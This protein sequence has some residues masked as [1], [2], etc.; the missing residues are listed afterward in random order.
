MFQSRVVATANRL[1]LPILCGV[2]LNSL[3]AR[4]PADQKPNLVLIDLTLTPLDLP[5]LVTALQSQFPEARLIAYGPHVQEGP[6]QQAATLG[7]Q[8]LTRGQFDHAME[9]VLVGTR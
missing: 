4:L 5:T 1:T 9:R 3:V 6:L 2:D 7:L 8:V